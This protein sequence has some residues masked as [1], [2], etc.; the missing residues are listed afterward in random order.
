MISNSIK[1]L[2]QI[3]E[4][5]LLIQAK[6]YGVSGIFKNFVSKIFSPKITNNFTDLINSIDIAIKTFEVDGVNQKDTEEFLNKALHACRDDTGQ[7]VVGVF[8]DSINISL[9]LV[10][11]NYIDLLISNGI[12]VKS[13]ASFKSLAS[14]KSTEQKVINDIYENYINSINRDNYNKIF[15]KLRSSNIGPEFIRHKINKLDN[16]IVNAVNT[17]I[18]NRISV[19]KI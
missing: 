17:K 3:T 11:D 1:D 15:F 5:N 8:F 7:C 2:I 13:I 16:Y 18:G 9:M 4:D 14:T 19:S 10:L 12:N 6:N